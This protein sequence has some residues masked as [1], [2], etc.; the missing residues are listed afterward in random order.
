[1]GAAGRLCLRLLCLS[2]S[3]AAS[4]PCGLKAKREAG[5]PELCGAPVLEQWD[6]VVN[7]LGPIRIASFQT[8]PASLGHSNTPADV[9]HYISASYE[10]TAL[11]L[12]ALL[13]S[14]CTPVVSGN[15]V[16]LHCGVYWHTRQVEPLPQ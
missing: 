6:L 3:S 11:I 14:S 12:L 8:N 4:L 2:G 7:A 1:M 16:K 5:T 15:N 13:F 10:Q 9:H